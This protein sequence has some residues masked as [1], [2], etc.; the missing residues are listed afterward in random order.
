MVKTIK[1]RKLGKFYHDQGGWF[2][3]P[4]TVIPSE[5]AIKNLQKK[6]QYNTIAPSIFNMRNWWGR[7]I[8]TN[9]A[10]K[11]GIQHQKR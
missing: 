7:Y 10:Q 5:S 8:L 9:L 1:R 6:N 4:A 3:R 2:I 11:A